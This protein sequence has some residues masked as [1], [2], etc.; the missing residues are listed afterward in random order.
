M[1]AFSNNDSNVGQS[2]TVNTI[3]ELQKVLQQ[4]IKNSNACWLVDVQLPER[5]YPSTWSSVVNSDS[6]SNS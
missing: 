6:E 2:A 1:K 4:I 3:D 5:D